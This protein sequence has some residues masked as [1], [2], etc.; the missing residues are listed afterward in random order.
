MA[1][2]GIPYQGSKQKI[3][4]EFAHLFPKAKHFYDLFGGGFSV[5]H[6]MVQR[7]LKDYEHFHFN[8]IRP[9]IC[10]LIQKAMR[11]EYSYK[12][13]KIPWV[14]REEF[15]AKKETDAFI[16]IIW[17]FGNNGNGYLFGADIENQKRSLHQ[18]IIFDQ[19]D[20]L[21]KEIIGFDKWPANIPMKGRRL[22]VRNRVVYLQKLGKTKIDKQLDRL[23]QLEQLER[24]ERLEQL[25]RLD[26]VNFYNLDYRKVPLENDA[27][28]YCDIPYAE[29]GEYDNN[30]HFNHKEF[31]EW[32][33]AQPQPVFISEYDV[34][35]PRFKLIKE[36]KTKSKMASVGPT[37]AIERVYVNKA[38]IKTLGLQ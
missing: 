7:R 26:R 8:E 16:K 29:T 25:E 19:F 9:G 15:F 11:G 31:F 17:S 28:I 18:A 6:F 33:D 10:E 23:Q 20:S 30:K 37:E 3:I 38:A 13:F 5:T 1:E 12:N 14:T 32:A 36:I 21:A 34:S 24:L 2:Y 22:F 27:I 4:A 35:D